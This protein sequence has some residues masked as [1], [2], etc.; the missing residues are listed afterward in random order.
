[1]QISI[2]ALLQRCRELGASDLHLSSNWYPMYRVHGSLQAEGEAPYTPEILADLFTQMSNPEQR[3]LYDEQ[4]ALDFGYSDEEGQRYRVNVYREMGRTAMAIRHLNNGFKSLSELRLPESVAEI[5]QLKKG[6][7]L[8][9]GATGSGKSTT[10]ATLID[11]I[12]S[13][14]PSH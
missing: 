10:L 2:N 5:A 13:T 4:G 8:V 3:R 14:R 1:M 9:T 6:L 12:N 7:V 11:A